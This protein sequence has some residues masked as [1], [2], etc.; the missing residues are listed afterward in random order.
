MPVS[1]VLPLLSLNPNI[2]IGPPI[3]SVLFVQWLVKSPYSLPL[4]W[5]SQV[6]LG[7][8]NPPVNA[9]DAGDARETGWI[10]GSG[11]SFAEGNGN[12]LQYSYLENSMDRGAWG[13]TV[14]GVA[15]SRTRLS[16][17]MRTRARTHTHT[18]MTMDI[19]LSVNEHLDCI[20]ILAIVNNGTMNTGCIYVFN[21]V[22]L[23]SV[24]KDPAVELLD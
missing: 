17:C 2:F 5:A 4:K 11:R 18:Y 7:V 10:P 15:M 23:F 12:P 13:A 19:H 1:I 24:V 6:A 22:F 21:L 16:A 9:E 14:H 3:F 8:K 20:H